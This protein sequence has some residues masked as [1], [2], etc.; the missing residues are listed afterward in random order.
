MPKIKLLILL[1]FFN[2]CFK[3][4]SQ[5]DS[6]KV[7]YHFSGNV[8]VTNNGISLIP[9]FSIG[10]PAMISLLSLGNERFSIDP[11]IRFNLEGKP[12]AL[13]FN[14]RYKWLTKKK[15]KLFTGVNY[16][17]NYRASTF[18]ENGISNEYIVA[19]R[20]VGAEISSNYF[21]QKNSSLGIY[22]L[23]ANGIDFGAIKHTHFITFNANF[24]RISLSKEY[25]ISFKPQIYKLIQDGKDGLF[26]NASI[27]ISK[28]N[29][30]ISLSYVF[31]KKIE[32][33]LVGV[34]DYNWSL[35]L[36][37]SFNNN[38]TIQKK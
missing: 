14:A 26:S 37:Y 20:Y 33:N 27:A 2:F 7:T 38:F 5:I 29:L 21:I 6:T 30:P 24:S 36:I 17:L 22:Y 35:N 31:N 28:N 12:W 3:G 25:Y 23:F 34:K 1:V 9:S 10:K 32:S 16:A 11:D 8:S 19:K 4:Y 18:I 15:L 13:V